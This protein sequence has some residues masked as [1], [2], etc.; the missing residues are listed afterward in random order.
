M[1][2]SLGSWNSNFQLSMAMVAHTVKTDRSE[3]NNEN[4][5]PLLL[6]GAIP[7]YRHTEVQGDSQNRKTFV[8]D[9]M[10]QVHSIK[11]YKRSSRNRK[12]STQY[13]FPKNYVNA[14]WTYL[15]FSS[16]KKSNSET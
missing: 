15:Q 16:C 1:I 13:I 10:K 3:N 6:Q 11:E 9:V 14:C 8:V 5:S 12:Y 2:I 7:D 4:Y